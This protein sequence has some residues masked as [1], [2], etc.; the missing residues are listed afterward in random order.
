MNRQP[1]QR[2]AR[3]IL[4]ASAEVRRANRRRHGHKGAVTAFYDRAFGG[5]R[6]KSSYSSEEAAIG[7]AIRLSTELGPRKVY[8]CPDCGMW[9]LTT[10]KP[11]DL[12][13][14]CA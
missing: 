4:E 5:C 8:R 1:R 6:T 13:C 10:P 2:V 14:E 9:H 11:E 7:A 12:C 3:S